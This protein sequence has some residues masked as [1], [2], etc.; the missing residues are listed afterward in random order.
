MREQENSNCGVRTSNFSARGPDAVTRLGP[1]GA[2]PISDQ[3]SVNSVRLN[4]IVQKGKKG[5]EY[6]QWSNARCVKHMNLAK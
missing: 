1:M 5:K 2:A 6:V 3:F 4:D